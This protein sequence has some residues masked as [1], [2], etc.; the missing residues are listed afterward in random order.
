MYNVAARPKRAPS[1]PAPPRHAPPRQIQRYGPC[2]RSVGGPRALLAAFES[3]GGAAAAAAAG[4]PRDEL[5][6][7]NLAPPPRFVAVTTA[8][9]LELEKLRPV[10]VLAQV[11][12][13][14]KRE[15]EHL[16]RKIIR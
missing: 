16:V 14:E 7:Q 12:E 10:D 3:S 6:L 8:G 11:G 2:R 5:S 13:R 4:G 9:V 15:A 1:R